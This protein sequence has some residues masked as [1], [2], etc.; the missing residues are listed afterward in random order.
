MKTNKL[1][2]LA[3]ILFSTLGFVACNLVENDFKSLKVTQRTQDFEFVLNKVEKGAKVEVESIHVQFDYDSVAALEYNLEALEF[4]GVQEITV[5][6]DKGQG[7]DMSFI[8]GLKIF[9][10]ADEQRT[11]E[12]LIASQDNISS[13][14]DFITLD[15]VSLSEYKSLVETG[16]FWVF[17]ETDDTVEYPAENINAYINFLFAVQIDILGD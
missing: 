14:S 6:L 8:R 2:F 11:D 10:S 17:V 5:G 9:V 15:V 3:L 7:F 4:E 12:V 13:G 16:D 1:L